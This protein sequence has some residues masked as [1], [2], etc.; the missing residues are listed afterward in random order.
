MI[1]SLCLRGLGH[2]IALGY[3]SMASILCTLKKCLFL[4]SL[5]FLC[6]AYSCA[7]V[8]KKDHTTGAVQALFANYKAERGQNGPKKQNKKILYKCVL[9]FNL[10]TINGLGGSIL[11]KESQNRCTLI[12]SYH[13]FCNLYASSKRLWYIDS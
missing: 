12:Q 13:E 8:D 9:E 4:L 11:S 2:A 10:A 5:P 6:V 3:V 1:T 7:V